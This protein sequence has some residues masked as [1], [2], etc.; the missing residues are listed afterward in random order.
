[1]HTLCEYK[2]CI[3]AITPMQGLWPPGKTS[4]T[5]REASQPT[6]GSLGSP[7]LLGSPAS[8]GR[9]ACPQVGA[10]PREKMPT[11]EIEPPE[12]VSM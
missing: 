9:I 4:Q 11:R 3:A 12:R 8:L 10:S 2:T 1:M 5:E 7:A 6:L